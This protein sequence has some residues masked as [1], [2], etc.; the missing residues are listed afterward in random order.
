[1][2][3]VEVVTDKLLGPEWLVHLG[4]T[5]G[6]MVGQEEQERQCQLATVVRAMPLSLVSTLLVA[7][8]HMSRFIV[9]LGNQ[10]Q[11]G[12]WSGSM[13]EPEGPCGKFS[14]QPAGT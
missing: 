8:T 2:P 1:M 11:V 10:P 14:G 13:L 5:F 4:V 7:K 6:L 3:R 9:V 12:G